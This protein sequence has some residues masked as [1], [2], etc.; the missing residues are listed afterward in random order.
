[1]SSTFT[2]SILVNAR[3]WTAWVPSLHIHSAY[4]A[5]LN[6]LFM[7]V[8]Q[9][10]TKFHTPTIFSLYMCWCYQYARS[11]MWF[12]SYKRIWIS[13]G[14]HKDDNFNFPERGHLFSMFYCLVYFQP[15]WWISSVCRSATALLTVWQWISRAQLSNGSSDLWFRSPFFTPYFPPSLLYSRKT[16]KTAQ[17]TSLPSLQSCRTQYVFIKDCQ[18]ASRISG[19]STNTTLTL[20]LIDYFCVVSFLATAYSIQAIFALILT[21]IFHKKASPDSWCSDMSSK[22]LSWVDLHWTGIFSP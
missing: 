14:L 10:P 13:L 22:R 6:P 1:M 2:I 19:F 11:R 3:S 5:G 15:S 4:T 9:P 17:P 20:E 18:L 7:S 12:F 21:L 8:I 16:T